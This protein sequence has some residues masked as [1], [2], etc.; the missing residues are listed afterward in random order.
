MKKFKKSLLVIAIPFL[1]LC[2]IAAGDHYFEI[3]KHI[4]IFVSVY[5]EIDE[6]YVDELNHA[7]LMRKAI[8]GMLKELDPYTVFYSESE[9]EDYKFQQTGKYG[10]IGANVGRRD[11]KFTILEAYEGY[12]ADKAGIQAGDIILSID[13]KDISGKTVKSLSPYLK[14][15]PNTEL[16]IKVERMGVEN[17]LE[18][19]LSRDEVEI[20]NVTHAQML[21]NGIGYVKFSNFRQGA[22]GEVRSNLDKFKKEGM[23]SFILDLRGNP[24]GLLNEAV[25]LVNLFVERQK[26]VVTTKGRNE[27]NNHPYMTRGA[28][29]DK[30]LPVVVLI[31]EG[32]A[33]ASEIVSGALQDYDRA[34][35]I[36]N[37]SFGK[38]LVQNILPLTYNTQVKVTI[39]KY[40]IPSG[41]CIQ[42]IDYAQKDENGKPIEMPDS[43]K[44]E[45]T[46]ANGRKVYD[47]AG[48]DPDIVI[49]NAKVPEIVKGLN[50]QYMIF[51]FATKYKLEHD[52]LPGSPADFVVSDAL[53]NEF[54]SFLTSEDFQFKTKTEKAIEKMVEIA[55]ESSLDDDIASEITAMESKLTAEKLKQIEQNKDFISDKL[56]LEI[57]SRYHYKKGRAEAALYNDPDIEAAKEVLLNSSKYKS[58][59]SSP[60]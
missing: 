50:D 11:G 44:E 27:N 53:F 52:V 23:E 59:L 16:N 49:K 46:T 38:G 35:V 47:G 39:S 21:D 7:K 26:M 58:V 28:A 17:P 56:R 51:D 43:L 4:D 40:Y 9:I 29:Y 42:R 12:S 33:S 55:K 41:R 31:D 48:V 15:E 10:G 5:K 34:V 25:S 24:G 54:K 36:G 32:S 45:F 20:A 2:S 37:T 13:G 30:K 60:N 14:G 18:F 3:T 57:V 22:A 6:Q 1:L 8:D 19:T